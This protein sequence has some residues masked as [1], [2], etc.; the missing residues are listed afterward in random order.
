LKKLVVQWLD[1]LEETYTADDCK[2]DKGVLYIF[3]DSTFSYRKV[4]ASIPT[5]NLRQ[6]KWQE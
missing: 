1:G 5:V 2:T 3:Q 4:L 6:W